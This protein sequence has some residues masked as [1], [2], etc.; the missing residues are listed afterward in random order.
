MSAISRIKPY[1]LFIALLIPIL[2]S[3]FV[4]H[5]S[6]ENKDLSVSLQVLKNDSIRIT[7]KNISKKSITAYSHVECGEKHYD[8]FEVEGLTPD[9]EELYFDFTDS[10]ERSAPVIVTLKPGKSFSHT[11]S[12][13]AWAERGGNKAMLK[14]AGFNYLPRGIQI[15]VKYYNSP[16]QDCSAYY[17]SIWTGVVYSGWV[18]F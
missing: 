18:K 10:R 14:K 8:W 2:L 1:F 3:S 16:C 15:R 9:H 6:E 7:V 5:R 13:A 17:K 11:L 12:L 4:V